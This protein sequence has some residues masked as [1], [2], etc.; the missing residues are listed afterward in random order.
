MQFLN[1]E[2]GRRNYAHC[3]RKIKSLLWAV[4]FVGFYGVIPLFYAFGFYLILENADNINE[5]IRWAIVIIPTTVMT[6]SAYFGKDPEGLAIIF[7]GGF[8][9]FMFG[10][11]LK[12]LHAF[13]SDPEFLKFL[14]V[15]C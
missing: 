12:L 4:A 10:L 2:H 15:L 5:L 13:L 14:E 1:L 11:S 8:L 3:L 9:L 7:L 6:A